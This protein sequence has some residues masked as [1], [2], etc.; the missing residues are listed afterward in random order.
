MADGA[1]SPPNGN[2]TTFPWGG[3]S[4]GSFDCGFYVAG[5][6]PRSTPLRRFDLERLIFTS[7]VVISAQS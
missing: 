4:D 2:T 3:G 7:L 1:P 6:A 5:G